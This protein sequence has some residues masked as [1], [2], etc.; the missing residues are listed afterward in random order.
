MPERLYFATAFESTFNIALKGRLTPAFRER[1]KREL[2]LDLERLRP[3]YPLEVMLQAVRLA[4]QE[5]F[6]ELPPSEAEAHLGVLSFRGFAATL[7]GRAIAQV[8]RL[9]GPARTLPRMTHNMK[10]GVN[11]MEFTAR[12][13]APGQHELETPD[14]GELPHFYLGMFGEGLR[15]AG[16]KDLKAE[17]MQTDGRHTVYRFTWAR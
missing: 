2:D 17:L 6:P 1:L 4:Q 12:E 16:A 3:A 5:Y 15:S 8:T 13:L 7:V 10:S 14:I 11:F 9:I